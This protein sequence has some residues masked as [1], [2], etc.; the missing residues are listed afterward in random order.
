[1]KYRGKELILDNLR[2][3]LRNFSVDIQDTVRS[4]ILDGIDISEY[5]NPCKDN[6][7]RFEQIRLA[8]KEG[9]SDVYF[10]IQNGSILYQIR[11]MR[12]KGIDTVWIE[13]QIKNGTL[14]SEH[15]EYMLK[16]VEDGVNISGLNISLIPKGLLEVFDHGMRSGFDMSIFNNGK[17]YRSKYIRLCLQIMNNGKSVS[18]LLGEDWDMSVLSMLVSFS[19]A[20]KKVW[21]SLVSNVDSSISDNRLRLLLPLVSNGICI[22]K[23]QKKEV[24]GYVYSDN[25]LGLVYKAYCDDLDYNVLIDTC[26]S[27]DEMVDTLEVMYVNKGKKVKGRVR[28]A[29][30]TV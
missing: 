17:S 6:P 24:S 20:S 19:K 23:L 29:S 11:K 25:C 12:H 1:M 18:F 14:S 16:W 7:H 15:F 28:K 10:G 8:K 13:N 21:D 3:V 2:E 9:M 27:Y 22:S 30:F 26:M 5:I 4:A